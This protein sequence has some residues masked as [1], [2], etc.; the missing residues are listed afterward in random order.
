MRKRIRQ[1]IRA[2]W[3]IERIAFWSDLDFLIHFYP[4]LTRLYR[5]MLELKK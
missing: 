3:H 1:L 4:V 2:C 5:A